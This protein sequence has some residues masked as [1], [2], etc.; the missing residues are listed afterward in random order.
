MKLIDQHSFNELVKA[1]EIRHYLCEHLDDAKIGL[2][3]ED[4]VLEMPQA[5][6]F[7]KID[8]LTLKKIKPKD[9]PLLSG[10][11]YL[12]KTVEKIA[13][14][15]RIFGLMHTRSFW[16]RLGLDCLGSSNYI[17]PGFG[18]E[19]ETPLVL[20]IRPSI[21]IYNIDLTKALA[22]MI[23]FELDESLKKSENNHL[24]RFPLGEF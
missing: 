23:L 21:T 10:K 19:K 3:I 12:A 5:I 20:E 1:G 15:S 14:S 18:N 22:A 2:H 8:L 13:I 7:N 24:S 6:D 4:T 16:A 17:S 9:E 11:F